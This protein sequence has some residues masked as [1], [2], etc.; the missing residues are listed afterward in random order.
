MIALSADLTANWYMPGAPRGCCR[1]DPL[2]CMRGTPHRPRSG[3]NAEAWKGSWLLRLELREAGQQ[4]EALE[5]MLERRAAVVM[6]SYLIYIM[7]RLD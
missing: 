3:S 1:V 4:Q 7:G 5:R 2:P 6:T